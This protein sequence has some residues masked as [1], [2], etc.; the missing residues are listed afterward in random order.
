VLG[1]DTACYGGVARKWQ[2]ASESTAHTA[3]WDADQ[4]RFTLGDLA[5]FAAW[6][7]RFLFGHPLA[8]TTDPPVVDTAQGDP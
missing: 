3:Y 8:P 7:E 4:D 5:A 1:P 2:L 6:V